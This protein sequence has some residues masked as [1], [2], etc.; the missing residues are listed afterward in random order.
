LSMKIIDR[1]K[2]QI[3]NMILSYGRSC[4]ELI[5]SFYFSFQKNPSTTTYKQLPTF[6]N[7]DNYTFINLICNTLYQDVED[8]LNTLEYTILANAELLTHFAT[9]FVSP[10]VQQHWS[11]NSIGYQYCTVLLITD[12]I[13]IVNT[14]TF[15]NSQ[16]LETFFI[17][18]GGSNRFWSIYSNTFIKQ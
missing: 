9:L 17:I 15:K 4:P 6:S 11:K 12:L 14:Y 13:D 7:G 16:E 2:S 10:I 5:N 3:N 8:F 18:Y 1:C